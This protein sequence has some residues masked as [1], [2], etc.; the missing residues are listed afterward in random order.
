[1]QQR[2]LA[3]AGRAHDPRELSAR[4]LRCHGVERSHC[5]VT[6]AVVLRKLHAPRCRRPRSRTRFRNRDRHGQPPEWHV[7]HASVVTSDRQSR[8]TSRSPEDD[9]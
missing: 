1:M 7:R 2:R 8:L 5:G 4:E 9:F 3:R 6:L